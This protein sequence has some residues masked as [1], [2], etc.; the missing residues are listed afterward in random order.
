GE[1]S[2]IVSVFTKR[3]GL[4]SYLIKGARGGKGRNKANL[5]F[6]SSQLEMIVYHNEQRSL[7]WIREFHAAPPYRDLGEDVVKTSVAIFAV[8]VLIQLLE[9]GAVQEE[10]FLLAEQF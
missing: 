7:Q 10:L 6:P 3:F 2:L 9:T 5:F 1:T 4:Q 8:E